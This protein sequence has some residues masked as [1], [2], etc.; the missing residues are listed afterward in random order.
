MVPIVPMKVIELVAE[1]I[2]QPIKP[3]RMPL[4]YPCYYLFQF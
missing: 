4:R 3:T 1:G 2:T